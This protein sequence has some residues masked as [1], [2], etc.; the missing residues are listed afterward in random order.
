MGL[1]AFL[2]AEHALCRQLTALAERER[3]AIIAGDLERLQRLMERQ[4]A[5]A[6]RWETIERERLA[7]VE[8]L[9]AKLGE[10]PASV[11]LQALLP[12]LPASEARPLTEL[13]SRLLRDLAKLRHLKAANRTLLEGALASVTALL[14]LVRGVCGEAARYLPTGAVEKLPPLALLDQRA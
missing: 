3:A 11:T 14:D 1:R 13:R 12:H 9:A 10:P 6:G 7:A 2:L 8:P 5:L 4:A